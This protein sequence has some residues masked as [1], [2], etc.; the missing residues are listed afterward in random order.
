MDVIRP[1]TTRFELTDAD[2][3]VATFTAAYGNRMRVR[4]DRLVMRYQRIEAGPVAL[5][6]LMQ[7]GTLDFAIEP[8]DER[9]V[10]TRMSSAR[11]ERECGGEH[12]RYRPG[13]TFLMAY[14][15]LPYTVRYHPG[16]AR[17]CVFDPAML[18][19]VAATA[20]GRRPEPLRFL[21]LDPRSPEAAVNWW[22][23]YGYVS[24]VLE[25]PEASAAPLVVAGAT[26]LLA[27]VTLATFPN[28]ALND[29]TAEDRHDASPA[30]LRRA[31]AYIEAHAGEDI[32]AADIA[33]A[34]N[35]TV[36]AVQLAF[37]RHRG[38][39]PMAYLRRVRLDLAHRALIAGGPDT[40][41][42]AAVAACWGFADHSRFAALYRRTYGVAP[43]VTL[44]G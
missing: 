26:Q 28:T 31:V 41:T 32:A 12:G 14:P 4:G 10:V 34:A 39:T 27:A 20:P 37:R 7:S 11:L 2:A 17:N 8:V 16:G 1:R 19:R 40:T 36:R 9:L 3:M 30:T 44:R 22:A 42:V 33:A 13:D 24:A 23:A 5:D 29:P 25:S 6:T 21:S 18:G 43:S 15:D 35:V 38:T